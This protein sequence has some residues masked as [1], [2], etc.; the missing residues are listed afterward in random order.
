[1]RTVLPIVLL[2]L[3]GLLVGGAISLRKQGARWPVVVFVGLLGAVA[4]AA[5][6]LWMET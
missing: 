3:A 6:I 5:G 2:G 1:M 4:A